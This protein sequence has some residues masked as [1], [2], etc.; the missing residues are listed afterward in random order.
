MTRCALAPVLLLLPGAALAD[1]TVTVFGIMDVNLLYGKGSISSRTQVGPGGMDFPRIGFSGTEDL[2]GGHRAVFWMEADIQPDSG[3][4]GTTN[5][6]NQADPNQPNLGG[7]QGIMFNRLFYVGLQA[8][9]GRF[10]TG[11]D[12]TPTFAVQA[13]YDPAGAGGLLGSQSAY[14]SLT[15][16]GN[17]TG[18][19]A[20]NS[21]A[22]AFGELRSGPLLHVSYALG[23]N[24]SNSGATSHDGGYRGARLAYTVPPIDVAVAYGVYKLASVGDIRERVIGG[25]FDVGPAKLWT[26]YVKDTTGTRNRMHGSMLGVT[27]PSGPWLFKATVSRAV[28]R[29]FGGTVIGATAKAGV[30]TSYEM[31][32]RTFL[33]ANMARTRNSHG[34][35][36]MP[37]GGIGQTAPNHGGMGRE[38]G[39]RTA[40]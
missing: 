12:Y 40:F 2:G 9:W 14:S 1:S 26:L 8:P 24:P 31:S 38:I 10:R 16:G 13:I 20:S 18:V 23:E 25:I 17:P 7:T 30:G 5:L 37:Q 33:Y 15:V 35:S 28:V 21:I 3:R 27:Y 22:F 11:R 32:K 34:A 19:R 36:M 39:L 6:N 29:N 4:G